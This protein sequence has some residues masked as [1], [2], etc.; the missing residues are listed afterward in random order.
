MTI[1]LLA[2]HGLSG[3]LTGL[4][5][6]LEHQDDGPLT[7]EIRRKQPCCRVERARCNHGCRTRIRYLGNGLA[8]IR[9]VNPHDQEDQA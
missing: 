4:G 8:S 1:I 6:I 3:P 7:I 5:G 2:V 9:K